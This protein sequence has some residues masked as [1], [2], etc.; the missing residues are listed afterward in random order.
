MNRA[1]AAAADS[2]GTPSE[3]DQACTT[4]DA[5]FLPPSMDE[6]AQAKP[7]RPRRRPELLPHFGR[8]RLAHR[9]RPPRTRGMFC[10]V[11]CCCED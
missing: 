2:H 5:R 10:C 1:G 7:E 3:R 9:R 4:D 6:F 11:C 8:E